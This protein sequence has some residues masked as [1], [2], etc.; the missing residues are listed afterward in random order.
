MKTLFLTI[1]IIILCLI[2]TKAQTEIPEYFK[3]HLRYNLPLVDAN[4]WKNAAYTDANFNKPNSDGKPNFSNWASSIIKNPSMFQA[5]EL[6]LNAVNTLAWGSQTLTNK[7]IKP[8]KFFNKTCNIITTQLL[9][10]GSIFILGGFPLGGGWLHEEYHRAMLATNRVASKDPF[11]DYQLDLTDGSVKN[12]YDD[13]LRNFKK[14]DPHGFNRMLIAGAEGELLA[15]KKMQE[16]NFFN[17]A[18]LPIEFTNLFY[19]ISAVRYFNDS[20]KSIDS[21]NIPLNKKDGANIL[22]RDFTG[23]DFSAWVWHLFKPNVSYDS[24][25][26][27]PSGVGINRYISSDRLTQ[28]EKDYYDKTKKLAILNYLSPMIFGFRKI[29]LKEGSYG[30][31]AMQYQATSFGVD[32]E[33][34][35]YFM[36]TVNKFCFAVHNYK[37]YKNNFYAAEFNWVDFKL[38]TIKKLS[39]TSRVLLGTQPKNQEFF[40]NQA[41]FFS[42]LAVNSNYNLTK[43]IVAYLQVQAKTAGWVAGDEYLKGMIRLR[44]GLNMLL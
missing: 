40:T 1:N 41:Q 3:P 42:L 21:M 32:M 27:H 22:K 8:K 12:I 34:R 25:G 24:L 37:N 20:Y 29:K 35:I 11:D 39:F 44:A 33:L 4:H 18:N 23:H 5:T 13:A 36:N 16:N 28:Q 30:N 9:S 31:F 6:N 17:G 10:G 7:L 14:N 26:V 38:K 19:T 2:N 15:A 43:N